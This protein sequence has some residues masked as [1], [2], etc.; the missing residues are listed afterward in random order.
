MMIRNLIFDFGKV[1][2]DYDFGQFLST[3]IDD[4]VTMRWFIQATCNSEFVNRCDKGDETFE[5]I[6][7]DAQARFPQYRRELQIFHDRQ[8]DALTGEVAGMSELLTRLKAEGYRLYGLTNWSNEVYHVM[9][10]YSIFQLLD[11][12]VISSEE[13]II[14]PDPAIYHRLLERFGLMPEECVFTDDKAENIAGCQAV[15]MAGI[16]FENAQQYERELRAIISRH[17]TRH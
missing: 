14:K 13:H 1:L 16:V 4:P 10:K 11:D 6:I 17:A 15:G 9:R 7:R 12:Q 3:F 2:V 8:T 5:E